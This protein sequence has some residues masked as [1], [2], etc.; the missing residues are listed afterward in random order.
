MKILFG[1]NHYITM[2][3]ILRTFLLKI[4]KITVLSLNIDSLNSKFDELNI[5]IHTLAESNVFIS[6]IC[7][8][9]ARIGEN[10][11][12]DHLNLKNYK[13]ITQ[14]YTDRCSRK[15]GLVTYL[16]N[17]IPLANQT[18]H[19]TYSTWEGLF[20]DIIDDSGK[21]ITICNIYRPPRNNNNHVS[22]DSFLL[23]FSPVV[24]TLS[25]TSKNVVLAGDFNI[26]LL[27]LNSNSKYQEFYDTL[28]EF[29]FLPIITLPTRISKI[30]ATLID[31][32]YSSTCHD[33]SLG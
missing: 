32:M 28:S 3:M 2:L 17:S 30:H 12:L 5:M 15:G 29:D 19:N 8:Q 26:D 18:M 31:H 21:K 1:P 23:D 27:K 22:I 33:R 10:S 13:I 14:A 24:Q 16:L 20:V 7:I 25:K 9:E 6:V 11:N 4:Q